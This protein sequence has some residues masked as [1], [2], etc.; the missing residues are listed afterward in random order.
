MEMALL[1]QA[2]QWRVR[3]ARYV[4]LLEPLHC[5]VTLAAAGLAASSIAIPVKRRYLAKGLRRFDARA[6]A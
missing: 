6:V 3:V 2:P 1:P 5:L 4:W